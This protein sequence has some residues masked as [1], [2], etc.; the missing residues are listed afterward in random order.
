ME[1]GI[2]AGYPVVDVRAAVY[3]GSY[4]SVD[5]S[6][7]AFKVAGS[8]AFKNAAQNAKPVLLEPIASLEI[9]VPE[10][11]AGDVMG[12]LSS[13]RGR[14][15]GMDSVAGKQVI[16]AEAPYAEVVTYSVQIKSLTH[17]AGA[18]TVEVTEY[19]EVPGD[20]AKKVIEQAKEEDE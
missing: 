3:D 18:Y 4:H 1:R 14:I 16:K 10:Q 11:Y 15:L 13:R 19:A 8:L 20:I 5:S 6:E 17:G 9:T 12:D 2:G 7:M